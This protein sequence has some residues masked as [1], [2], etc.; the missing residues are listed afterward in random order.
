M[1]LVGC[2]TNVVVV[3]VIVVVGLVIQD[4]KV[5]LIHQVNLLII[6]YQLK[7]VQDAPS[8]NSIR[9]MQLK[10]TI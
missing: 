6:L 4:L 1:G 10:I 9:E 2:S 8:F 7:N 5:L 3:V